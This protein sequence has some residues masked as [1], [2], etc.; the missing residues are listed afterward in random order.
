MSTAIKGNDSVSEK[1]VEVTPGSTGEGTDDNLLGRSED[2]VEE[3]YPDAF[4]HTIVP[5]TFSNIDEDFD[6]AL[7]TEYGKFEQATPAKEVVI[8][9]EIDDGKEITIKRREI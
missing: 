4:T 1:S 8:E 7:S 2:E 6:P 5:D 3:I 9:K